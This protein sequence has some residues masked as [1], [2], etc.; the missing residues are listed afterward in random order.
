MHILETINKIFIDIGC[1]IDAIAGIVSQDKQ[2][3]KK[4]TNYQIKNYNLDKIDIMD[5]NNPN[6]FSKKYNT[7][8]LEW[9]NQIFFIVVNWLVLWVTD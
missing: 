4:W 7:V 5:Q 2:Y 1:G 9:F 3:F 8:F 6:R